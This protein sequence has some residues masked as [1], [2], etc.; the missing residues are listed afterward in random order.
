MATESLKINSELCPKGSYTFAAVTG[1]GIEN[2]NTKEV[3]YEYVVTLE[4]DEADAGPIMDEIDDYIEDNAPR[5]GELTKLPY[6]T[7]DDY[8]GVPQGKIWLYAK[9][10]TEITD[11]NGVVNDRVINVY[12]SQGDKVSL[13]EGTGIGKGSTGK[14]F[15]SM[16]VWEQGKDYGATIWLTGVQIADFVPY[17]FEEDVQAMEGGGS[18]KGFNTPQLKKDEEVKE[19]APK[20]SRRSRRDKDDE[21]EDEKPSG[22]TRRSRRV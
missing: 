21:P 22:R 7:H 5:K 18:F 2:K 6:Q 13:P 8:D 1:Q 19:E 3:T 20:R 15:G 16:T 9:A 17:E 14:L 10:S 12:D 4:L 11:R